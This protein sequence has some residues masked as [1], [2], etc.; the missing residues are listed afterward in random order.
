MKTEKIFALDSAM[1]A[2][3]EEF[4][5]P[6]FV[7]NDVLP[8]MEVTSQK[9]EYRKYSIVNSPKRNKS[10]K[11]Q[12]SDD[13]LISAKKTTGMATVYRKDG[14]ILPESTP[15]NASALNQFLNFSLALDR[16]KRVA[17]MAFDPA[18]YPKENKVVLSGSKRLLN[19]CSS[20]CEAIQ[21]A[22]NACFIKA[23]TAVISRDMWRSISQNEE[24]ITECNRNREF[25][26]DITLQDVAVLFKLED[27]FIG[28]NWFNQSMPGLTPHPVRVWGTGI[29]LYHHSWDNFDADGMIFG[30]T[31]LYGS[32]AAA[33]STDGKEMRVVES[34]QEI[35]IANFLGFLITESV[36]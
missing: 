21:N 4:H 7:A 14:E 26:A 3:S 12:H 11:S 10:I 5:Y 33:K 27:V 19:G 23:N 2:K 36:E 28:E 35:I 29:L 30:K 6:R 25:N 31:A 8:E 15:E 18:N 32:R 9:F 24:I 34:V 1:S 13:V 20:P 22:I 17:Q 16:E